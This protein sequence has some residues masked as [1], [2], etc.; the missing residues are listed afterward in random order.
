[1]HVIWILW[2]NSCAVERSISA[3]WERPWIPPKRSGWR[4]SGTTSAHQRPLCLGAS[5][6]WIGVLS[7]RIRRVR[8]S[9]TQQA[10]TSFDLCHPAPCVPPCDAC[11]Y[12]DASGCLW[13]PELDRRWDAALTSVSPPSGLHHT[14]TRTIRAAPH[15]YTNLSLA[16][17]KIFYDLVS[18]DQ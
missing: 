7:V 12:E 15:T 6:A 9:V 4:Q 3:R 17:G 16:V 14:R 8:R 11:V 1:M 2:V 5:V 13:A 18:V 10:M